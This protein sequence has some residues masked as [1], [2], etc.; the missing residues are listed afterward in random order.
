MTDFL[1]LAGQ[2]GG[3]LFPVFAIAAAGYV[4][5]RADPTFKSQLLGDVSLHVGVPALLFGTLVRAQLETDLLVSAALGAMLYIAIIHIGLFTLLKVSG[6]ALQPGLTGLSFGNWGN[7]GMPVCF[8]AFGQT[9][10]TIAATFF[11]VSIFSQFTL[12]WRVASGAWDPKRI[13]TFPLLWALLA[14][15]IIRALDVMPPKWIMDSADLAGGVAIPAMLL[16]LGGGIA[17]M[18]PSGLAKGL[19]WAGIRY[20]LGLAAGLCVVVVLPIDSD[21]KPIIV[22]VAMMPIAVFNYILAGKTGQDDA[23]VAGYIVASL[24]LAMVILPT[25]LA[26]TLR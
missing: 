26:L 16:A 15:V 5:A 1:S 14:A 12:G 4:W 23:A 10:L 2:I 7:I 25:T 13:L 22:L 19:S 9:G 17:R 3:I 6:Q 8:F 11:A 24:L 18:Q 21:I 20:A